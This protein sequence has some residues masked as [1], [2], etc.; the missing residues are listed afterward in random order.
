[1]KLKTLVQWSLLS[2]RILVAFMVV[3]L[4]VIYREAVLNPNGYGILLCVFSLAYAW[5]DYTSQQINPL[6]AK[7][8]EL[9]E[10][11][12]KFRDTIL[13]KSSLI[14]MCSPSFI[15]LM[16]WFLPDNL[17]FFPKIKSDFII[18]LGM[19]SFVFL[20]IPTYLSL[21]Y[22]PDLEEELYGEEI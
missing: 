17:L 1:M 7:M 12:L 13:V 11:Q 8:M 2:R 21:W 20:A 6:R 22:H 18:I 14:S 4:L 19:A 10:W 5:M 9:D 3:F 15:G 16:Y